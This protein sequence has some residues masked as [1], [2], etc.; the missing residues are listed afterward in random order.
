VQWAGAVEDPLDSRC[1]G[2][3]RGC[4]KS[5]RREPRWRLL[6][7]LYWRRSWIEV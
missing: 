1:R 3:G 4:D 2:K 6:S 7:M 5:Q